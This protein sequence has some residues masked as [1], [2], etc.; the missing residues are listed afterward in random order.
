MIVPRNL[1]RKVG[2]FDITQRYY[3]DATLMFKLAAVESVVVT[4]TVLTYYFTDV[5]NNA[6]SQMKKCPP[7]YPGY[8]PT[9][10]TLSSCHRH[11]FWLKLFTRSELFLSFASQIYYH[12]SDRNQIIANE[13]HILPK[14]FLFRMLVTHRNSCF[15]KMLCVV[16]L[17][18]RSLM[19][20][21]IRT[22]Y[23]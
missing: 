8:L 18:F 17:K 16:S 4:P 10:L 19:L 14:S 22:F 1:F 2:G 20:R 13:L 11:D 21:L 5:A 6:N 7:L 23:V 12:E 15:V 3:E 9:L